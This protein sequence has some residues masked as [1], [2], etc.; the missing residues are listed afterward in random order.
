[1]IYLLFQLAAKS[2]PSRQ[3]FV[4]N[5]ADDSTPADDVASSGFEPALKCHIDE[6]IRDSDR[7]LR[8][9]NE[10]YSKHKLHIAANET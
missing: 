3:Q 7:T 4:L 1:M 2:T 10:F 9:I 6:Y 5:L 8:V